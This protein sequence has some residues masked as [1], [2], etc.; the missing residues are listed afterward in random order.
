MSDPRTTWREE[1]PAG[2]EALHEALAQRLRAMAEARD[3]GSARR[4]LHLKPHVGVEARF[5]VRDDVPEELRVGLF[6]KAG[7]HRALVRFSN[8]GTARQADAKPDVRGI[9]LKIFDVP[10]KKLIPGLEDA[11]T[12]DFLMILA[13]AV[14]FRDAQEFVTL[15]TAAASPA[16]AL[17]KL[18]GGL[19]FSRTFQV[20]GALRK[21]MSEIVPSLATATYHT[22][23]PLRFGPF[24]AKLRLAATTTEAGPVDPSPSRYR[25]DLAR[26]IAKGP[27]AWELSA[28]L[29]S[30]AT[31]TP[32]EDPT[33]EWQG[34]F[35][36]LAR[37]EIPQQDVATAAGAKLEAAVEAMSFDP[38]HALVE[39]RPLGGMMRARNAAY[40]VSTQA[41]A[42]TSEASVADGV[43]W[44]LDPPA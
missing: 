2:E 21:G 25:E 22:A 7:T 15:V 19:G 44:V 1:I 20:L 36:P 37:L 29:Y 24:A 34:P 5:V 23:L 10:G 18:I 33:V 26:R 30:D 38:W 6:A 42:A 9:A 14:P 32:I 35:V 17:F 11:E 16:T 3:R 13:S 41:R 31:T 39:H 40:R 43:P 27:L 4:I 28:Q 8:G 12:Q